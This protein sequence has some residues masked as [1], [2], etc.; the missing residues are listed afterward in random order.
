MSSWMAS[1]NASPRRLSLSSDSM[2]RIRTNPIS[3]AFSTLECAWSEQ[4]ATSLALISESWNPGVCS[5]KRRMACVRPANKHTNVDSL[6]VVWMTPPPSLAPPICKNASGNPIILPS[7]FMT[8]ISSSVHAGD[9]AC[10]KKFQLLSAY[11]PNKA[12]QSNTKNWK[13]RT[14]PGEAE[15]IDGIGQH[16]AQQGWRRVQGRKVGVHMWRLPMR[17]TGHNDALYVAHD[18]RPVFTL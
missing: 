16:V 9:D 2:Y 11:T 17:H 6:A 18:V 4:Y 12:I 5:W 8:S 13:F 15:T 1:R 3:A 7:Q 14:N 10:V